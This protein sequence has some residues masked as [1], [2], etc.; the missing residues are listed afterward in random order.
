MLNSVV[1]MTKGS[2]PI[3]KKTPV[4]GDMLIAQS[5]DPTAVINLSLVGAIL[6]AKKHPQMQVQSS[7]S[8]RELESSSVCRQRKSSKR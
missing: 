5:G 2:G 6:E 4:E 7:G 8:F 3:V 1:N